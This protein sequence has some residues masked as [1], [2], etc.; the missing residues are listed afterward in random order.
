MSVSWPWP[1]LNM[2]P[3]PLTPSRVY[4]IF[5]AGRTTNTQQGR[6]SEYHPQ[7][8]GRHHQPDIRYGPLCQVALKKIFE[9][10]VNFCFKMR[11]KIIFG[12][13]VT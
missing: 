10:L 9:W 2:K 1:Q 13:H 4:L 8:G 6:G 3:T 5:P 12:W 11:F 7:V